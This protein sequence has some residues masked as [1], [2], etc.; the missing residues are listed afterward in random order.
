MST[1]ATEG[2]LIQTVAAMQTDGIRNEVLRA[3][4]R[5]WPADRLVGMLVSADP[6]LLTAVLVTLGMTGEM[7]HCK[8]IASLLRHRESP[9][10]LAAECALWHIWMRGGSSWGNDVLRR[11]VDEIEAGNYVEASELLDNLT[12]SEPMFAE[13]HH[14]AGLTAAMLGRTEDAVSFYRQTLRL[15]PYHFT[16]AE[17][18]GQ[19][20][21][22]LAHYPRAREYYAYAVQIHPR[23]AEAQEMLLGLDR[24]IGAAGAG[25]HV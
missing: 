7:G 10:A 5:D 13:A 22:D 6:D 14:Q 3:L 23:R 20:Y 1:Y 25:G 21:F 16:A 17:G 12:L 24:V 11:A 2:Q 15:N 18:L 8:Y 4:R 9:V 19:I